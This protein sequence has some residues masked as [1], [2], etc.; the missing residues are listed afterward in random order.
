[1]HAIIIIFTLISALD[2]AIIGCTLPKIIAALHGLEQYPYV[3][4]ASLLAF[5][6]STPIIGKMTDTWGCYR[7]AWLAFFLF[8]IGA[9][10]SACSLGM[11][12]LICARFCQGLGMAGLLGISSIAIGR[13][14]DTDRGRSSMQAYMSILWAVAGIVGPF[15]AGIALQ[16]SW[17]FI[18]ILS[19][20]LWCVALY[21]LR[22]TNELQAKKVTSFD[23]WGSIL[24]CAVLFCGFFGFMLRASIVGIVLGGV[25]LALTI[26]FF[27]HMKYSSMPLFPVHLLRKPFICACLCVGFFSGVALAATYTLLGLFVQGGLHLTY[28]FAGY[29]ITILTFG[30]SA[31]SVGV[32]FLIRRF[33]IEHII[34]ATIAL[35]AT[36]FFSF[37][38]VQSFAHTIPAIFGL[39]MGLGGIINV[40]IVMIQKGTEQ[41]NLGR[42]TAFLSLLRSLG[43]S[44]GALLCGTAQLLLFKRQILQGVSGGLLPSTYNEYTSASIKVLSDNASTLSP[45]ATSCIVNAYASSISTVFTA[46]GVVLLMSLCLFALVFRYTQS[47]SRIEYIN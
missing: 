43:N 12:M 16:F 21:F 32:S 14:F 22:R 10:L 39:G 11:E 36:C 30:W 33:A 41:E 20:P 5:L 40:S 6:M 46:I 26:L 28:T 1:M 19:M 37:A 27:V 29:A 25:S 35:L 15:L 4:A 13:L 2:T 31:G 18:F 9:L 3:S 23:L 42:S 7:A 24:F 17:R 45:E 34:S 38:Y 8:V 47:A 44:F